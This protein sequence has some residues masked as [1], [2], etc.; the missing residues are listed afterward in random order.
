MA[1][2]SERELELKAVEDRNLRVKL[3]LKRINYSSLFAA[4]LYLASYF[5]PRVVA[6]R[7]V[8]IYYY[9]GGT[10][11]TAFTDQISYT[12]KR[13]IRDL[14]LPALRAMLLVSFGLML[15]VAFLE[16]LVYIMKGPIRAKLP[17][18]MNLQR[19][20]ILMLGI[21]ILVNIIS[22]YYLLSF[23]SRLHQASN[24][25]Y[26]KNTLETDRFNYLASQ[27]G[28]DVAYIIIGIAQQGI[29]YTVITMSLGYYVAISARYMAL[30]A[31]LAILSAMGKELEI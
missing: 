28:E 22:A 12:V 3:G 15:L 23:K 1:T 9:I 20:R 19:T 18:G 21:V 29:S 10:Q 31:I 6:T 11:V 24:Y 26:F 4:L 17:V 5:L 30:F 2:A 8:T 13:Y 25:S 27:Y 7:I 14:H 16:P